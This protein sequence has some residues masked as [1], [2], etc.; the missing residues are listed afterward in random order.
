VHD[1]DWFEGLPETYRGRVD[2]A[3]AYLP[4]VPT[5]YLGRL[6]PDY[7]RA[8]PLAAVHGGGDGLDPLRAVLDQAPR[9]LRP[10]GVLVTMSAVDQEPG[11]RALAA[12][13]GW[14][15]ESPDRD[16]DGFYLLRRP[17]LSQGPL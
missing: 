9:W 16:D 4:H 17:P 14:Q 13:S 3:V 2:L 7:R 8:E 10:G 6:S 1:G 12:A 11:V 15:V 5:A